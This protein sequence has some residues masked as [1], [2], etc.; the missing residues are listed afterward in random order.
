MLRKK[1]I[2]CQNEVDAKSLSRR[3]LSVIYRVFFNG[4]RSLPKTKLTIRI[5]ASAGKDFRKMNF[6]LGVSL[7]TFDTSLAC[8]ILLRQIS[9]ETEVF[10]FSSIILQ[11]LDFSIEIFRL[12]GRLFMNQ[13]DFQAMRSYSLFISSSKLI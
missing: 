9:R 7:V 6:L 3:F 12:I 2:I 11:T 4:K 1:T 13:S 8:Q 5:R 10:Q